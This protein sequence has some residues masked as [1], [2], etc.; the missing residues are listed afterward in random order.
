MGTCQVCG[1]CPVGQFNCDGNNG[2]GCE[3][4]VGTGCCGTSCQN[5][6]NNGQGQNYYDCV[7]LGTYNS[8]QAAKA[9]EAYAGAGNCGTSA[10]CSGGNVMC[11]FGGSGNCACWGYDGTTAGYVFNG[12]MMLCYCPIVGDPMWN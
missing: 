1:S 7:A 12:G 3:C 11:S 4:T 8:T 6:H 10:G 5:T 9:C 2:N